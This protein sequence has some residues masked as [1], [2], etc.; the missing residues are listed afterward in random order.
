VAWISAD[1][2][3][4][5]KKER[6][7]KEVGKPLFIRHLLTGATDT[8][9]HVSSCQWDKH[10]RLLAFVTKEKK[11]SMTVGIYD[12]TN[13]QTRTLGNG[14]PY[15]SLPT[16]DEEGTQMLWMAAKD[17]LASGSKHCELY[18][19]K[20]GEENTKKLVGLNNLGNLP[21]GWGI[22][23]NSK[24]HFS[25][26]GQRIFAGVV[27]Y[28]APKDTTLVPFETAGLDIWN[29]NTTEI[30]PREK[31]G[32]KDDAK[33]THLAV[34]D[35]E[36][37]QLIPLTTSKYDRI[38]TVNR[39]DAPFVLSVDATKNVA[40]MQWNLNIRE[41]VSLVDLATGQRKPVTEGVVSQVTASPEG[42]FITWYDMEQ[43]Q[44]FVYQVATG[45]IRNVTS[46]LDVNVW[47]EEDDHPM[48]PSPYG[49]AGWSKGDDYLFIYDRYDIWKIAADGKEKPVCLT[50]GYGRKENRT[51]RY[52]NLKSEDGTRYIEPQ[53]QM[54]LSIFDHA[55][56]MNGYATVCAAKPAAPRQLALG[57]YTYNHLAKAEKAN[58]Y[59]YEKGNF[60]QSMD[61]YSTATIGN[62][63]QKLTAINPQQK[64]YNWGTAELYHWTAYDGTKLDGILYKPEDFDPAKKYPVMIYFYEKRSETLYNYIMPQPSWSTVNLTFY[65]SRGY[66]VFVPDIVYPLDG[67]P[68]EAAYNCVCSGAESLTK[69]PWIDKDNMA[70]QGQ[71]WGGYQVAYLIARTNMFKAAGAGAPVSNM[72]SAYGGIRLESG[73][74]R[75]FQY[76]QTQSRVGKTLWD[77]LDLYLKNSCLF[78]LPKV[79]TPVLIM[80]NDADGAVPWY[81][82]IEMFMGLRRLQ[83]PAWLLQYNNEAHNLKERRNR[84]DLSIRL[85]Q[86]FDHYLKGAP[87][88][89]W[90]KYG[91]P[92]LRKGE[93]FGLENANEYEE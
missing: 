17:T 44:W 9:R 5:P 51:F 31:A 23:E 6:K 85:Q 50:A 12:A 72:T 86:F 68:G 13:R 70:I 37:Q 84:K 26:N 46:T 54:T 1:T 47:D 21:K 24:P 59:I 7:D 45:Q 75:Q 53:E 76:E 15:F 48:L 18:Y 43:K 52:V 55:T 27:K 73:M 71:S 40:E 88:P 69:Y 80:H 79:Q 62:K 78:S 28:T 8:L 42:K 63:E 30:P 92:A 2:A 93:Y 91:V 20:A 74:S 3:F 33:Y 82:G 87:E 81:Q 66:V 19:T 65:T 34:F 41:T 14:L 56:K 67:L 39:G 35:M 77:G 49:L 57:G 60:Q 10:G 22:T 89:A 16:F 38:R 32:L 36:R 61:L 90:M 64:D 25:H 58:T 83:K 4:I 29:W 11:D